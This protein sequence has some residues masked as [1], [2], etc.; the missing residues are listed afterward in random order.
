MVEVGSRKKFAKVLD[1]EEQGD[2]GSNEGS[3]VSGRG[4]LAKFST[5][6]VGQPRGAKPMTSRTNMGAHREQADQ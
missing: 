6:K 1:D 5:L 2:S 3:E 4:W